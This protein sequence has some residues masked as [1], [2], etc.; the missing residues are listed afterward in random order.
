MLWLRINCTAAAMMEGRSWTDTAHET[1]FADSARP[2][3]TFRR[4]FGIY[5][6]SLK[7][8]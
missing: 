5:L 3:R 7:H 6:F 4:T 8:A 1:G 2:S